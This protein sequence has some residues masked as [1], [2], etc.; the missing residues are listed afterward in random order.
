MSGGIARRQVA[1]RRGGQLV[2]LASDA[3]GALRSTAGPPPD[4]GPPPPPPPPG[5]PPGSPSGSPGGDAAPAPGT[6]PFLSGQAFDPSSEATLGRL[7][8]ESSSFD[9]YLRR[10]VTAGFDIELTEEAAPPFEHVGGGRIRSGPEVVGVYWLAPGLVGDLP[11]D[12]ARPH[13]FATAT[14]YAAESATRLVA[15]IGA[16]QSAGELPGRLEDAGFA[17]EEF[18]AGA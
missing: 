14:A 17:V 8:G 5:S 1:V 10:L 13:P 3:P 12:A 18:R 6:H 15:S 11:G 4:A 7:L 9:D 16:A 2:L